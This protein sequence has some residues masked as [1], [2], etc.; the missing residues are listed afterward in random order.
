M[1]MY[2]K[3][4]LDLVFVAI[5]GLLL[6]PLIIFVSGLI[7]MNMGPPVF[8]RQVRPGLHCKPFTLVKFRT[9]TNDCDDE[10]CLL[11]DEC[12]L[13]RLGR[14]LR[15]TSID[16]LPQLWN[17]LKGD[18]SLV[19]PRPLLMQYICRYSPE[20][21]RRHDAKPGI[22]GWAQVNGRNAITWEEKFAL[23]V[24]YVDNW[25]LWLDIKIL[26]M[27]LVKVFKGEGISHEG[28]ATMEEFRGREDR[29][30]EMGNR[31]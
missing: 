7:L 17:V 19:G 5:A 21:M 8:F 6:S 12:R 16:E 24:W 27:T 28:H 11:P 1:E 31:R 9:M 10:G 23:D 29:R 26:F 30:W 2:L 22:T 3:R 4:L 25:S 14:F 20:Q 13:T 18:L 15:R